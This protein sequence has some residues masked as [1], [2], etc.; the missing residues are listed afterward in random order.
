MHVKFDESGIRGESI[1]DHEVAELIKDK[2]ETQGN[3]EKNEEIS[4][5]PNPL[6]PLQEIGSQF[7]IENKGDSDANK[8]EAITRKSGWR[9]QS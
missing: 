7:P 8:E 9:N 3:E 4:K 5:R 2:E 1:K 6:D